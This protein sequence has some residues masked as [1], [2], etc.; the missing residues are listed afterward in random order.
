MKHGNLKELLDVSDETNTREPK[1]TA[2][3]K[4]DHLINSC[5]SKTIVNIHLK[6]CFLSAIL[7]GLTKLHG[8]VT[9]SG[10]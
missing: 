6:N 10:S 8:K 2:A 3:N 7:V 1:Y 4:Q 5:I 9:I